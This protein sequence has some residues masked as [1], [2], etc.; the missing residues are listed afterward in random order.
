SI[1]SGERGLGIEAGIAKRVDV[2]AARLPNAPAEVRDHAEEVVARLDALQHEVANRGLRIEDVNIRLDARS[3]AR[4]VLREG[5]IL[6]VGGPV[7]LGGALNHWLPFRAA[8][9]IAVRSGGDNAEPAMRAVVAGAVFVLATYVAQSLLVDR[10]WGWRVALVYLA[11]LPI[12]ADINFWLRE[13]V[14]R[15]RRRAMA[16]LVFRREPALRERLVNELASL[17]AAVRT[18]DRE[19]GG[20][21]GLSNAVSVSA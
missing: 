1:G 9:A 4:F 12:A 6:L 17:R 11:S 3:G 14:V 15:A 19:L 18:L 5:W 10:L 2:L 21:D 8:R 16:F 20:I 13:R 7:A